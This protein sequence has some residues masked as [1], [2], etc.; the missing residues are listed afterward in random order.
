[1]TITRQ[2]VYERV[3]RVHNAAAEAKKLVIEHPVTSDTTLVEPASFQE[4]TPTLYRFAMDLKAGGETALRVREARLVQETVVLAEMHFDVL[5]R[6]TT[7]STVPAAV[8]TALQGAVERKLAADEAA[9]VLTDLQSQRAIQVSEQDRI[10][11]NLEAA[12]AASP[13][14]QV[15]LGRLTALDAEI[16]GLGVQGAEASL[17]LQ[18]ARDEYA[19]YVAALEL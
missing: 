11:R 15:Y 4:R 7:D 19:R 2:Q 3:Y 17:K 13:Q 5:V 18:A 16:D 10:R 14:G 12:G 1:M 9:T 6:Y 8:K